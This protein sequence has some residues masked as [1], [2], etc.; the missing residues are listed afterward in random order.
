MQGIQRPASMKAVFS[1]EVDAVVGLGVDCVRNAVR[2]IRV[3]CAPIR[4][5]DV[6]AAMQTTHAAPAPRQN[7]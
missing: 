1:R 6:A 4:P 7:V 2:N 5:K 3:A